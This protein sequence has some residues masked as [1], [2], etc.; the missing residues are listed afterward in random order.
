[1]DDERPTEHQVVE[2]IATQ[3]DGISA[4]VVM[5]HFVDEGFDVRNVQRAMQR[6][7]DR[8]SLELGPKL[9]LIAAKQ[10][11]AA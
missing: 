11:A 1:M 2:F 3:R 5:Q 10:L 8:G 9:H 4:L 6:A 7:L